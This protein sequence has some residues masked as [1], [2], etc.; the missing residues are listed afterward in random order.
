MVGYGATL[1][2]CRLLLARWIM[3]TCLTR[4]RAGADASQ[5]RAENDFRS[6]RRSR[7]T[8]LRLSGTAVFGVQYR[9]V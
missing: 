5:A 9:S 8:R 1:P 7:F 6:R 2:P 3:Q 4:H